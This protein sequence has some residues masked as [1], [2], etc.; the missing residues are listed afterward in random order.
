MKW[1]SDEV[2]E[3]KLKADKSVKEHSLK[4]MNPEA[5]TILLFIDTSGCD[6]YEAEP[7]ASNPLLKELFMSKY[8][9]GEA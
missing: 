8:N 1:S 7:V 3:G 2:Y 6:Q 4:D 5:N 9:E